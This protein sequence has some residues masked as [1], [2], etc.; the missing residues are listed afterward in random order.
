VGLS[1][2]GHFWCNHCLNLCTDVHTYIHIYGCMYNYLKTQGLEENC[3]RKKD[4]FGILGPCKD[5]LQ[6]FLLSN[7]PRPAWDPP[8]RL[9]STINMTR[10]TATRETR[11][12][13]ATGEWSVYPARRARPRSI[14]SPAQYK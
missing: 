6:I 13:G 14:A 3:G 1:K 9:Q 10:H 11:S 5:S 2:H 8:S 7:A 12:E 4:K